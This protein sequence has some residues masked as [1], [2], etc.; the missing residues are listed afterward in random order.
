MKTAIGLVLAFAIGAACRAF[1]IPVPSP[2]KLIGAV[3]VLAI[4]VGYV[5]AD[6]LLPSRHGG[7]QPAAAL[8]RD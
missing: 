4:T 1:D 3:L 6:R 2:Q 5:A 7:A 8:R